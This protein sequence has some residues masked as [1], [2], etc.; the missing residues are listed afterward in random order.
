MTYSILGDVVRGLKFLGEGTQPSLVKFY[1]LGRR[2]LF[3]GLLVV[4]VLK[5]LVKN[6]SNVQA[7]D[8]YSPGH[9]LNYRVWFEMRMV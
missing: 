6:L 2:F 3:T 7:I 8:M 1:G 4:V 5:G 9:T